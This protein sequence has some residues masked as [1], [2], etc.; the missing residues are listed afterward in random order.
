MILYVNEVHVFSLDQQ[1]PK[2][3]ES[4]RNYNIY[5]G[6]HKRKEIGSPSNSNSTVENGF[7][8]YSTA[9]PQGV[10]VR[11]GEKV[12]VDGRDYTLGP[13]AAIKLV[14]YPDK[15]EIIFP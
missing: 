14:I 7:R 4:S 12:S 15:V 13:D 8:V 1:L 9:P 11:R 5:H 3:L 6:E 10:L 2:N